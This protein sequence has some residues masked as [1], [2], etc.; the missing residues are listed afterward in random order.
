MKEG[1]RYSYEVTVAAAEFPQRGPTHLRPPLSI[2][3]S[4]LVPICLE[5]KFEA[6]PT[7]NTRS[8]CLVIPQSQGPRR[9]RG[10]VFPHEWDDLLYFASNCKGDP[11]SLFG[12]ACVSVSRG[13]TQLYA[14]S[15]HS[16]QVFV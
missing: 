5:A 9:L 10:F 12:K 3:E 6:W 4:L 13:T 1:L 11:P 2:A 16:E 15:K 7:A 8:D 14:L